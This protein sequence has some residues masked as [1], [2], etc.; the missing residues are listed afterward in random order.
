[1]IGVA[2]LALLVED[3]A[4]SEGGRRRPAPPRTLRGAGALLRSRRYGLVVAVATILSL[5]TVSDAF[6]YLQL[7]STLS[8]DPSL[9]PLL[10]VGTAVVFMALAMPIGWIAD[11]IG[12]PVVFIAGYALQLALYLALL[13]TPGAIVFL[14]LALV[15]L[16]TRYAATDGVLAAIGSAAAPEAGRGTRLALPGTPARPAPVAGPVAVGRPRAVF[17]PP[18]GALRFSLAL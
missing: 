4:R 10:Y 13:A 8:F 9:F 7:Q 6:V 12:R 5:A 14:P 2:I 16:G 17:G 1:V 15:A 11:Q 3:P 18:S